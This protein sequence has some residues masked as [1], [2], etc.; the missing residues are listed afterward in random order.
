MARGWTVAL[1]R[2]MRSAVLG[3]LDYH[4]K[5][6]APT[7]TIADRFSLTFVFGDGDGE[8]GQDYYPI[9]SSHGQFARSRVVRRYPFHTP[10]GGFSMVRVPFSNSRDVDEENSNRARA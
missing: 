4:Q 8:T 9:R 1:S 2:M 7:V 6:R 10:I 5:A 3:K